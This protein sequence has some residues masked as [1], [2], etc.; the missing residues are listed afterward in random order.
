V[1]GIGGSATVDGGVGMA[2]A[3]GARFLDAE[4]GEIHDLPA[5][6]EAVREIAFPDDFHPPPVTVA[7]DVTNPLLG[8]NGSV[9]IYGP[10]KG[11][12]PADFERYERRLAHL[13][14][15]TGARGREAAEAE[16]AGA[17]GGLGF[18]CLVFLGAT[19]APGFDLVAD[20]LGLESAI[21]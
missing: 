10:Q 19:L 15:L 9:A 7:C 13:V 2:R 14:E 12:N 3:L 1:L 20:L 5:G 11:V 6:L 8:P 17:A 21:S 16:G 4:G 18:G